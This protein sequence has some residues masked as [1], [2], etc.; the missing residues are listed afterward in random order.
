MSPGG[1]LWLVLAVLAL[2]GWTYISKIHPLVM[3]RP[4]VKKILDLVSRQDGFSI[5]DKPADKS[6]DFV[7][8]DT[9]AAS[10]T[11]ITRNC[12]SGHVLFKGDFDWMNQFE[13]K[14]LYDVLCR[15]HKDRVSKYRE[16]CSVE[17]KASDE[18]NREAAI[19]IYENR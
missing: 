7:L 9:V 15:I 13:R 11:A 4:P 17:K 8:Y 14:R 19:K 10:K 5:D 18:R 2:F 16:A 6:C 12:F 3:T 1:V